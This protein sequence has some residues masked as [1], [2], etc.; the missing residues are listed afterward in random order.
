MKLNL[1]KFRTPGI[2]CKKIEKFRVSK[3]DFR[4]EKIKVTLEFKNMHF[5]T[6]NY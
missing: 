2:E 1:N 3:P 5:K 6:G 4:I